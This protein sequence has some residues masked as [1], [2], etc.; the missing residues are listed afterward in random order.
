M[1][2]DLKFT[3]PACGQHMECEKAYVGAETNCLNCNAE[4]RIPFSHTPPEPNTL[5][6][7]AELIVKPVAPAPDPSMLKTLEPSPKPVAAPNPTPPFQPDELHCLC[8][9]CQSELEVSRQAISPL[10]RALPTAK[11]M[12][13][14]SALENH[15]QPEPL[16][17]A[18]PVNLDNSPV[19]E[20]EQK[21]A[22]ARDAHPVQVYPAMK[23][24]MSYILG[25]GAKVNSQDSATEP[26]PQK[27]KAA[28]EPTTPLIDPFAE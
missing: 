21:I 22:A 2:S 18:P 15:P 8:P 23:P 3:C 12:K 16:S 19:S 24:R 7:H 27:P 11:L 25:G 17:D 9:V 28:A 26:V 13:K 6:P 20:R 5:L 4:L 14:G 10:G 1:M